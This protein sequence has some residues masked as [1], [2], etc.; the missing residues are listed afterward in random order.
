MRSDVEAPVVARMV[1]AALNS[2]VTWMRP[3]DIDAV[4]E[5]FRSVLLDGLTNRKG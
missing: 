1:I 3:A 4:A 2:A 5:Q